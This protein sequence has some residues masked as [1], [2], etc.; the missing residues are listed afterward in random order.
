MKIIAFEKKDKNVKFYVDFLEGSSQHLI[1][2]YRVME[3]QK[4]IVVDVH[5]IKTY[6]NKENI[7]KWIREHDKIKKIYISENLYYF[8]MFNIIGLG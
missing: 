5:Q 7:Y 3:N 8:M 1:A 4:D 2:I 6:N